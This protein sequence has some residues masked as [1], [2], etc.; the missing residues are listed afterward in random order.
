[1]L[2]KCLKTLVFVPIALSSLK[3]QIR[4]PGKSLNFWP[5]KV[6]EPWKSFGFQCKSFCY[7]CFAVFVPDGLF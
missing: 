6:C 4:V 2:T 1:M 3:L 5:E 7:H